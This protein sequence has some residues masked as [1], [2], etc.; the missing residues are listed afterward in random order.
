MTNVIPPET[1]GG[2]NEIHGKWT[3]ARVDPSPKG[4]CSV[5]VRFLGGAVVCALVLSTPTG[6]DQ[7]KPAAAAA[8]RVVNISVGDPVGTQMLFSHPTIVAKPGERLKI[9]LYSMGQMPRTVMTHN[10]VL[11]ALGS[12]P[13]K[14][15]DAAGMS[16]ATGYI[17]LALKSQILAQ[18]EMVGPGERS[19]VVFTVPSKPGSYPYL[20][21]FAG[22]FAA[23]MAGTLVV[24]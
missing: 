21:T 18:T 24:K 1:R 8:P 16:P 23:G 2:L 11:L 19:E 7:A 20:C 13:K 9:R 10:W 17:P 14:F 15:A 22:H 4:E 3:A 5:N 6:A 12:D